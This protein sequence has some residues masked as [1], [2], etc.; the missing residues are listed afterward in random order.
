MQL[1]QEIYSI[2]IPEDEKNYSLDFSIYMVA[3]NLEQ[4]LLLLL[5]LPF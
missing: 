2:A 3:A 5:S 1:N 4:E